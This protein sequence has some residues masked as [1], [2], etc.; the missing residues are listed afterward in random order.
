M[1]PATH[2]LI[3]NVTLSCALRRG[4]HFLCRYVAC[5]YFVEGTSDFDAAAFQL[6]PGEALALDPQARIA[7]EQTQVSKW[8]TLSCADT[9]NEILLP[10]VKYM[11]LFLS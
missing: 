2:D 10:T 4:L 9:S 5:G 11:A 3:A 8:L 7:L 1:N 6:P